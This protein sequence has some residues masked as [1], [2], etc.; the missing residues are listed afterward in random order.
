LNIILKAKG[1]GCP[2]GMKKITLPEL[3]ERISFGSGTRFREYEILNRGPVKIPYGREV[4]TL[5]WEGRFPSDLRLNSGWI[6]GNWKKP[7]ELN[8]IIRYWMRKKKTIAL[9]I[10]D[11]PI[12]HDYMIDSYSF[13]LEGGFGDYLYSITLV[14]HRVLKAGVV[15]KKGK[16][17]EGETR[18]S[19]NDGNSKKHTVI[20]GDTLWRLA[21]KYYKNGKSYTKIYNANKDVIEKRAKSAGRKSSENGHWIYPGT[22]LKIP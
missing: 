9:T 19:K 15:R 16:K 2:K 21:E 18:P 13:E 6:N 12:N 4:E 8:K 1:K 7:R 22:V 3:P 20:K 10:T 5:T 14:R 17:N 11:S